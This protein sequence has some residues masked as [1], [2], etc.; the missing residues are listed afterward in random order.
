MV[1]RPRMKKPTIRIPLHRLQPRGQIIPTSRIT[2]PT[3]ITIRDPGMED[4]TTVGARGMVVTIGRDPR[5]G[6]VTDAVGLRNLR[7][8]IA[9]VANSRIRSKRNVNANVVKP[10][11]LEPNTGLPGSDRK[12]RRSNR[13]HRLLPAVRTLWI[14]TGVIVQLVNHF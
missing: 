4:I 5:M 14:L 9:S 6:R 11:V 3:E 12:L 10:S 2:R 8:N 7:R 1:V 13:L